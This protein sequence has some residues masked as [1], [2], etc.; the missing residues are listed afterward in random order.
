MGSAPPFL[1]NGLLQSLFDFKGRL[2][3]GQ[4]EPIGYAK[5]VGIDGDGRNVEQDTDQDV[6]CL[7]ADAGQ[8]H[9][10]VKGLRYFAAIIFAEDG[11]VGQDI[12]GL[13]VIKASGANLFFEAGEAEGQHLFCRIIFR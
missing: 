5:D 2:A 13:A 3:L 8:F 10:F 12:L 1:G 4:L 11:A 7:A 6:G 9:Q